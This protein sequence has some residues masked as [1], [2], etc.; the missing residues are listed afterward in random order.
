MARTAHQDAIAV[1]EASRRNHATVDPSVPRP[2]ASRDKD[3]STWS[4]RP[5]SRRWRVRDGRT[6]FLERN[7]RR[8]T[9]LPDQR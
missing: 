4:F 5:D 9:S 3:G 8:E 1:R 6:V 2:D 7:A